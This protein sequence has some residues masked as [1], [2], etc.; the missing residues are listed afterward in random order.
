MTE[1]TWEGKKRD[2]WK[3]MKMNHEY[4]ILGNLEANVP[5]YCAWSTI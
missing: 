2:A 4:L 1:L 3:Q 5:T